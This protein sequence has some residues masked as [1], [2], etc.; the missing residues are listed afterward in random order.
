M[1]T[2]DKTCFLAHCDWIYN[3]RYKLQNRLCA[4]FVV[5]GFVINAFA[6]PYY[7]YCIDKITVRNLI[8]L[9]NNGFV[10]NNLPLIHYSQSYGDNSTHIAYID[11]GNLINQTFFY[12]DEQ[13]YIPTNEVKQILKDL[14]IS[15][16]K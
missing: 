6:S 3:N 16:N 14:R 8:K 2:L 11:N 5:S 9:W 10:Y 7:S 13:K 12:N 15:V 4:D 1:I